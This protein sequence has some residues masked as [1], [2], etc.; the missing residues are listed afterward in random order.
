[1]FS[2]GEKKRNEMLQMA[3]LEPRLAILDETDS[4]LDIDALRIVA[5]GVNNLR[6]PERALIVI[7]HYQ[8]LLDYIV[9]DVVHVL[10]QG[11]I[12]RSGGRELALELEKRGYGWLESETAEP[13]VTGALL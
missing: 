1:G 7:T 2:G 10:A 11:R 8:R 4:G 12:V 3:L 6:S 5:D 13:A 9:P